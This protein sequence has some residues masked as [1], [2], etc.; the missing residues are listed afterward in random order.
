VIGESGSGKTTLARS[1]VGILARN[2][3]ITEGTI[4]FDGEVVRDERVARFEQVRGRRIGMVFQSPRGSMNP[5]RK[6]GSQ[7]SEVTKVR[8]PKMSRAESRERITTTLARMGFD[9]PAAIMS[10]Y[11]H[12]LSGGMCQRVAI[13]MALVAKPE[14]LIADECTSALDV[15]TQSEVVELLRN[16]CEEEALALIFVTHDLLLAAQLCTRLAVMYAGSIVEEGPTADVLERPQHPYTRALLDA[17][18]S[19][20]GGGEPRGIP[21]SPPRVPPGFTGCTFR[22]RCAL[23]ESRC[24]LE[25]PRQRS[26]N[27][28]Y[29][30]VRSSG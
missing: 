12:E 21:G 25:I 22:D 9:D 10:A 26:G 18:P 29:L 1:L 30:C 5:V 27:G 6:V 15:T 16:L 14:L 8:F 4:R 11:P 20:A 28:T 19:A 3:A 17:I 7:L 23:A 24:A 13:A 2:V